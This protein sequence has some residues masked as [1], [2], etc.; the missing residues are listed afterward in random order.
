[1]SDQYKSLRTVIFEVQAAPAKVGHKEREVWKTAS[2]HY[3][4]KNPSGTVDYF[5]DEQKAKAYSKGQGRGGSVDHGTV[6]SSR[7]VPLDQ[8]GYAKDK[9]VDQKQ[10]PQ[11]QAVEA[12]APA[13]ASQAKPQAA[14]Q[15]GKSANQPTKTAKDQPQPEEEHPD[16][17]AEDPQTVF[18]AA[19]REDPVGS[20]K[21]K[22]DI[23][24][25][26]VVAN[27]IK[28]ETFA[29]PRDDSESVFGDAN[30]EKQFTDEMNHAA[31]AAL[32]GQKVVDFELC[33]KMFSQVG[34]C[35]DRKGEKTTKGIVRKEMPQFSS[36][37]DPKKPDSPAFKA[38]M[39]GKGYTSPEQV[40]PEDLKL[41]VNMEKAYQE[42]LKGAGYEI[43][44]QEVDA[45]SLKPIQGELLGS[46]VAAMY[47]TL[48]AAQ[49]DPQNYG[50]AAA[51]LLEPIYVSDGYVIDGH[52]RWAAQCAVDIANGQG[53]NA[54]MRTRTITKGGKAVPID[55][56]IQ[57]SNKFQQDAGLMSQSRS[58]ATVGEKPKAEKKEKPMKEGF[59][60]PRSSRERLVESLLEAVKVKRDR[61]PQL[62]TIGYGVDTDDP[63]RFVGS[64]KPLKA[65]KTDAMGNLLPKPSAKGWK[66]SAAATGNAIEMAQQLIA[67]MNIKPTGTKFEV[68]GEKNGKPY[69]LKVKKIKKMGIDTYETAGSR[70]VELKAAGTGL[71]VLDKRTRKIVLDR[72]NDM[73]WD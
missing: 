34:F 29:G 48:V 42:A 50:K 22:P 27:A 44:D 70:E 13:A 45:T 55:E 31:L 46:K 40:T 10:K 64:N 39:A 8:D 15:Q 49:Q 38:L 23:R 61:N 43:N 33:D 18:D 28:S 16:V 53:T 60:D 54:T 41:E 30:A 14:P 59:V 51:R 65:R 35:Y 1:M 66:A 4:A 3:G 62:G 58:G 24:K 71:Q 17:A 11:T 20:G 56:I 68:Y 73:L 12:P 5:D 7:E 57:F 26:N 19:F 47:G 9:A 25:A 63:A 37:V 69:T 32:R 52:H 67:T 21:L 72:G 2:G 36:Q 6:D